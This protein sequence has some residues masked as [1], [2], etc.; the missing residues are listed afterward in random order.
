VERRADQ[1]PHERIDDTVRDGEAAAP[2]RHRPRL[3]RRA[4]SSARKLAL[5]APR[6]ATPRPG[7][8][9]P[10]ARDLFTLHGLIREAQ[11]RFWP[12]APCGDAIGVDAVRQA[13]ALIVRHRRGP[14]GA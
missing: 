9:T 5:R 11:R 2:G 7:S 12:Y 13:P 6:E 3:L 1:P 8:H 10:I 4:Y 14:A